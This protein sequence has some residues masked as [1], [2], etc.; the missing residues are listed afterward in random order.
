MQIWTLRIDPA[1]IALVN[2]PALLVTIAPPMG[3]PVSP[4]NAKIVK[5]VE[6]GTQNGRKTDASTRGHAKERC[7]EDDGCVL[8]AIIAGAWGWL[9]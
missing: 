1:V 2:D 3:N 8:V 4:A 9:S 6:H 5:I 7:K